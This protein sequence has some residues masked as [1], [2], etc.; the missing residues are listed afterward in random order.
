MR[1]VATTEPAIQA[2]YPRETPSGSYHLRVDLGRRFV[3][4]ARR[5]DDQAAVLVDVQARAGSY[6]ECRLFLFHDRGTGKRISGA[7]R[8][9]VVHRRRHMATR[10][11]EKCEPLALERRARRASRAPFQAEM[12]RRRTNDHAPGKHFDR[13]AGHH[14]LEQLLI[15]SVERVA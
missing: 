13:N 8:V 9:T 10:F 2:R 1:A 15:A 14:A 5:P 6:Y 7:Q 12:R 11:G 3:L 4:L